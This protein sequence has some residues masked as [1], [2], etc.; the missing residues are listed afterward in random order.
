VPFDELGEISPHLVWDGV[1]GRV[2]GA[3]R[4]SFAVI[5]LQ[6]GTVVPEH[7]HENE[8]V[9]VLA[10]GS[11]SFRIGDETRELGPGG[12]WSIPPNIPHE[13]AAEQEGAVVIEVFAPR[14]DDWDALQRLEPSPPAWPGQ[15]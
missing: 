2:V 9:G 1:V 14:R 8:Q 15:P 3:G 11:V 12:T 5:E 7:A 10:S 13:V 4:V 6:P